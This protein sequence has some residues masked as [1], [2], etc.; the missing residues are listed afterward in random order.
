MSKLQVF[1]LVSMTFAV[2]TAVCAF[3]CLAIAYPFMW[4]WNYALVQALT[5]VK[6][7]DYWIAFWLMM[8][9]LLFYVGPKNART[10]GLT[11]GIHRRTTRGKT[12]S[13]KRL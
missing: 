9:I 2:Y 8:T 11:H 13:N 3:V 7:I 12:N 4:I 1:L 6:P 10:K 5:I